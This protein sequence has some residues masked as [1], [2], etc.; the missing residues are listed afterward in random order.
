MLCR[1]QQLKHCRIFE[2]GDDGHT[3][4]LREGS[5]C[6]SL[7]NELSDDRADFG[8]NYRHETLQP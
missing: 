1:I 5:R 2:D 6:A 3:R 8:K 4:G 7:N